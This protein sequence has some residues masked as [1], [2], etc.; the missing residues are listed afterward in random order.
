MSSG[1]SAAL[2]DWDMITFTWALKDMRV[3]AEMTVKTGLALTIT[4]AINELVKEARRI[5]ATKVPNWTGKR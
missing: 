1:A 4:G 5:K 3:V 2:N